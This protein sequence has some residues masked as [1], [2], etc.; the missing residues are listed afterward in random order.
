MTNDDGPPLQK[1]ENGDLKKAVFTGEE[2]TGERTT[3]KKDLAAAIFLTGLSFMAMFYAWLLEIPDSIF[4]APGLLPFFTGLSLLFMALGLGFSAIRQG[5][6]ENY[7]QG[8][9]TLVRDYF[10]NIENRR[11]FLLIGIIFLWVIVVGQITFD[12]RFP[13]PIYVFRFSS[14]EAISIPMLIMILRIFWRA[15]LA[16]C[17]VVSIVMI[18]ALAT[19][20]RDGFKI[21]LPEAG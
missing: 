11:T 20:F 9:G 4:T 19:A 1:I 17:S 7:F 12:F 8:G 6:T 14:Y 3:P 10:A 16:R 21:L 13:T 18:I 15:S 5:A 2:N